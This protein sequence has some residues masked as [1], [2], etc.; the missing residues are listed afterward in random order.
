MSTN[1]NVEWRVMAKSG[2]YE[3]L[4]FGVGVTLDEA[5][6]CAERLG[7]YRRGLAYEARNER[8]EV[9]GFTGSRNGRR[10]L[11][12]HGLAEPRW[13]EAMHMAV[14]LL[15]GAAAVAFVLEL[16]WFCEWRLGFSDENR[17]NDRRLEQCVVMYGLFA[18]GWL[19]GVH[20]GTERP[21]AVLQGMAQFANATLAGCVCMGVVALAVR[22]PVPLA[23][24]GVI[25]VVLAF[26]LARRVRGVA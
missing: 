3:L 23:M 9:L 1:A 13:R 22:L 6:A 15:A 25:A 4:C 11:V 20:R 17:L 18:V 16:F 26:D 19:T 14:A 12:M 24:F 21:L 10:G 5:R 8:G 2:R 7:L